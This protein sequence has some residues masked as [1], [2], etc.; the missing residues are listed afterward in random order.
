ML[1][2]CANLGQE[3]F[4][5]NSLK[6]DGVCAGPQDIYEMTNHRENLEGLTLEELETQMTKGE[7]SNHNHEG[8]GHTQHKSQMVT[9]KLPSLRSVRLSN[10]P[11]ITIKKLK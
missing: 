9:K 2:G 7:H 8:G 4:T 6:K 10:I 1:G 3:E 5:C 11:L